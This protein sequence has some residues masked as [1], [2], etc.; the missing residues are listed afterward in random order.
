MYGGLE[1]LIPMSKNN[2]NKSLVLLFIK[3]T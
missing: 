2:S 3:V 1:F